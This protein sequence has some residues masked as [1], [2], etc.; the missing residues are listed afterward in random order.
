MASIIQDLKMDILQRREISKLSLNNQFQVH[1]SSL[2]LGVQ[3]YLTL[4]GTHARW[5][6]D[7]AGIMCHEATL[8]TSSFATAEVKDNYHGINQQFAHNR[9]YVESDFTFYIDQNY[10]MIKIFDGWM[11]YIAGDDINGDPASS[12]FFRR[13]N[14]PNS[15]G[16]MGG[17]KASTFSI[18]KFEKNENNGRRPSLTYVFYNMFPK[19][20]VAIPV[21]YGAADLT[22]VTV[23]FQY[24]RYYIDNNIAHSIKSN[25]E[26][27]SSR[28]GINP[29]DNMFGIA[30]L[31]NNT[32][33]NK[34][35]SGLRRKTETR[36]N[37]TGPQ[38]EIKV[39]DRKGTG[40]SNSRLGLYK[41]ETIAQF[42]ASKGTGGSSGK[43]K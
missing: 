7:N 8:P 1:I 34:R 30:S 5:I 35:L 36:R 12:T 3:R 11:D 22:R 4:N 39:K 31:K 41:N 14:Y 21:Q 38:T 25:G 16:D 33:R 37:S 17:Y 32:D 2:P 29:L 13:F 43:D 26:P 15:N 10:N 27:Q 6:S 18:T 24:D 42:K 23:T 20:M 40:P 9:I 28:S 19:S